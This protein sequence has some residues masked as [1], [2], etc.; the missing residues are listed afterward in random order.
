GLGCP[1]WPGCY[2]H[3]TVPHTTTDIQHVAT[4]FPGQTVEAPKAWKEMIHRYFAGTLAVLILV[5]AVWAVKRKKYYARQ[6][7]FLPLFLVLLVIFQAALGM[8]TVT[9]KVLP[10]IVSTH[11]LCGLAITALL[12][13]LYL[14]SKSEREPYRIQ[15][16]YF[17]KWAIL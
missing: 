11:L 9:W 1:D 13:Y 5:L 17:K 10:I 14:A 16:T 15:A 2:G 4:L 6:P 8:W 3:L 12:W 7:L